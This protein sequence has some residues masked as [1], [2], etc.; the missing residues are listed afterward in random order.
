MSIDRKHVN[1]FLK[2]R[3]VF[4]KSKVRIQ[5][6]LT[7]ISIANAGM[8]LF[9]VL[10]KLQDYNVN[11]HISKWGLPIYLGT[12]ILFLGIGWLDDKVGIHKE[13]A[14]HNT[15]RNPQMQ[16]LLETVK[17]LESKVDKLERNNNPKK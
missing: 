10:S 11:I 6:S 13:E 7:Y 16:E 9:L 15:T 5:R 12:F 2:F 4:V 1:R 8:I 3:K 14:R 17:R